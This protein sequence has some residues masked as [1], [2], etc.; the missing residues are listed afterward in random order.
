MD[1]QA[2]DDRIRSNGVRLRHFKAIPCAGSDTESGSIRSTHEEHGC[3]NGFHYKDAGCF[4]GV[5]QN[6]PVNKVVRPEGLVDSSI[7][8]VLLPRFYEDGV[9]QMHFCTWDR[10]EIANCS[11]P[12]MWVPYWQKM[13][14]SQT[15]IDRP[16]FPI[17]KIEYV[18][19]TLGNEYTNNVDFRIVG[20]NIH[21]VNP[22]NQPGFDLMTGNGTPYA[23]RYLYKP[24]MYVNRCIHQIRIL[25]TLDPMSGEK[26]E[27]RFPYLLECVREIEFLSRPVSDQDDAPNE[28]FMPGSG[29]NYSTPK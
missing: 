4:I 14:Y 18:I 29:F 17:E 27:V 20:G 8:Y 26:K 23:V 3:F 11:E 19:D 12:A 15:R 6:N 9:E 21:W 1:P 16:R 5:I 2:F 13:Q 25:N 10:I 28:D 7:C 24:A 22:T